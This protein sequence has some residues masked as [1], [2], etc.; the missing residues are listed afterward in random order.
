MKIKVKTIKWFDEQDLINFKT[1]LIRH[2]MTSYEFA[3]KMGVSASFITQVVK[4]K[5]S[6]SPKMIEKFKK[7]GFDIES[8]Y[9]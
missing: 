5:K 1:Y 6:L 4:G 2:K 9:N 8:Y 3:K 7:A